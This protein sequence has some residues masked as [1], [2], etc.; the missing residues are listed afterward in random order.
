MSVSLREILEGDGDFNFRK[1]EDCQWIINHKTDFEDLLEECMD[2]TDFLEFAFN[3]NNTHWENETDDEGNERQS[4]VYDGSLE[5]LAEEHDIDVDDV[6][7]AFA[8][9]EDESREAVETE[10]EYQRAMRGE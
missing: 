3:E 2:K 1:I 7:E 10:R 5:D 4:L 9:Y 6:Y 8:E